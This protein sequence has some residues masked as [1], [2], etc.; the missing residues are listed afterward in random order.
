MK[1]ETY[2][3]VVRDRTSNSLL[4][5]LIYSSKRVIG[6]RMALEAIHQM[7]IRA[8]D[9]PSFAG[10][11]DPKRTCARRVALATGHDHDH[12]GMVKGPPARHVRHRG[13]AHSGLGRSGAARDWKRAGGLQVSS[14]C[15]RSKTGALK[16]TRHHVEIVMRLHVHRKLHTTRTELHCF[17]SR[18][19]H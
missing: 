12:G 2:I 15:M 1:G 10:L 6:D 9:R 11:M 14:Q 17:V 16:R 19:W 18:C 13:A 7:G 4:R 8:V 3:F 5:Y